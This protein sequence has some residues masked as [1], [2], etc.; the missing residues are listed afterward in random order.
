MET[1]DELIDAQHIDVFCSRCRQTT[2]KKLK[3]LRTARDMHCPMCDALIVLNTSRIKNQIRTMERQMQALHRQLMDT[4]TVRTLAA[5]EEPELPPLE[6][7]P[8][9]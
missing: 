1:L 2:A 4:I 8:R 7:R 3:A 9:R 5:P 6:P